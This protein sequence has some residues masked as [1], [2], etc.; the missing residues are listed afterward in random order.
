M[1]LC[2]QQDWRCS[3]NRHL[4]VMTDVQFVTYDGR[5]FQIVGVATEKFELYRSVHAALGLCM[6]HYI[7]IKNL[8]L[9]FFLFCL[10]EYFQ[11]TLFC[12]QQQQIMTVSSTGLIPSLTKSLYLILV[13]CNPGMNTVFFVF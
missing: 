5:W 2:D 7:N 9:H 3:V 13:L 1:K 4:K 12:I 8:R 6:L 10:S 11:V